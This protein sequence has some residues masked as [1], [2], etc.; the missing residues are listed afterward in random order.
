V[1]G[2]HGAL[3]T[4]QNP[5]RSTLPPLATVLQPLKIR[6][7]ILSGRTNDDWPTGMPLLRKILA[8]SGRFEVREKEK[9]AGITTATLA[10][11]RCAGH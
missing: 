11:W 7:L 4:Y 10:A 3:P 6:V 5:A 1:S 8:N 2:F 9:L